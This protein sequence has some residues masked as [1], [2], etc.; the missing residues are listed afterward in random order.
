[1]KP[2]A[3][4]RPKARLKAALSEIQPAQIA[5]QRDLA[6]VRAWAARHRGLLAGAGAF[7]GGVALS[8]LPR[9]FWRG[10]GGAAKG[11]AAA[12]ARSFLAP[13]LA[14]ALAAR[15]TAAA[16]APVKAQTGNPPKGDG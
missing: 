14:A 2:S 13:M 9:R 16:E 10:I 7:L 1:M 15:R 4:Q 5:L 8:A 11:V 3:P 6:T 12:I